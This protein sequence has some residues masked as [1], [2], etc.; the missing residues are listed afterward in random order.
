M[1]KFDA[2]DPRESIILSFDFTKLLAKDEVIAT[3]ACFTSVLVGVDPTHEDMIVGPTTFTGNVC[4]QRVEHGVA[5]VTYIVS[6]LITTSAGNTIVLSGQM[7][8][9]EGGA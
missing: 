7:L 9:V 6:C 2:K 1:K 8:M 3:A 4:S 5:D